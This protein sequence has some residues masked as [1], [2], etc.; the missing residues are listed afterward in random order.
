MT[1][2]TAKTTGA[3]NESERNRRNGGVRDTEGD[4][5][6][7]SSNSSTSCS[8]S[9]S[10]THSRSVPGSILPR[11]HPLRVL[12]QYSSDPDQ[13]ST[14]IQSF[15]EVPGSGPGRYSLSPRPDPPSRDT[16]LD[17]ST[18]RLRGP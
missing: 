6:S 15:L 10:S 13:D 7:P 8:G 4:V 16:Y 12:L 5:G 11:S 2:S 18:D 14:D 17:T 9:W 1:R 3:S